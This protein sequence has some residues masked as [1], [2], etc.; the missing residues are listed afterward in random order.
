MKT[1]D[2]FSLRENLTQESFEWLQA[3]F[4]FSQG[5]TG[6][7]IG[8]DRYGTMEW[9]MFWASGTAKYSKTGYIADELRFT[10]HQ[11]LVDF[12]TIK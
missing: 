4:I 2:K 11:D 10:S 8:R 5:K 12:L 1:K 3:N 6:Q 9:C 7:I